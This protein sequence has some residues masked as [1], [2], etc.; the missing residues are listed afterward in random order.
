MSRSKPQTPDDLRPL[1]EAALFATAQP[2]ALAELADLLG[3]SQRATRQAIEALVVEYTDRPHGA[4]EIGMDGEGFILQVKPLF[5]RVVDRLL[6]TDLPQSVLRTLS[7]IAARAPIMQRE[8]VEARGSGAYD[9]I[10]ELAERRLIEKIP[11]GN[12]FE[13]RVGERFAEYFRI[14]R[15]KL[16]PMLERLQSRR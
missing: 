13:L 11:S 14:D 8:V 6:P 9:H 12:S 2:I 4:L 7:Y 1:V 3:A 15:D 10:K 16:A 5:Q